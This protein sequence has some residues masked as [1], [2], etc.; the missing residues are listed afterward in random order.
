MTKISQLAVEIQFVPLPAAE[1]E[2]RRERLRVL[3]L[4]GALRIVRQQ[5]S[6]SPEPPEFVSAELAQ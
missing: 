6:N 1:M 5:P 4:R 2:E 3:L